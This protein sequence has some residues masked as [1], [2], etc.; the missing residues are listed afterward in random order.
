M[1]KWLNEMTKG[2]LIL[3]QCLIC[4]GLSMTD[5]NRNL[6]FA[7]SLT[8]PKRQLS[9]D[10]P[11]WTKQPGSEVF[12]GTSGVATLECKAVGVNKVVFRCNDRFVPTKDA[13]V[14]VE[15]LEPGKGTQIAA[16]LSKLKREIFYS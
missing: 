15:N 4:L 13:I 11:S 3:I 7:K 12:I 9:N 5:S 1:V 10:P 16:S 8:R 2:A 6:Y 14:K